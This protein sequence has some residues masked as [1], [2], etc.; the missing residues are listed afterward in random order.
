M[1]FFKNE[2]NSFGV[3]L[4]VNNKD[5]IFLSA[6]FLFLILIASINIVMSVKYS[7]KQ[8]LNIQLKN[9]NKIIK[10]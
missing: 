7:K 4:F 5:L 6:I 3:E 2:I 8:I 10:K 1:I 9:V